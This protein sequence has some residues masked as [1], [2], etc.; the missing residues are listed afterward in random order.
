M[1]KI[2]QNVILNEAKR[3]EESLDFKEYLA[4]FIF[5]ENSE[6]DLFI[7]KWE[8]NQGRNQ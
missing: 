6:G 4:S 3:N 7:S 2:P 5:N 8:K 1:H